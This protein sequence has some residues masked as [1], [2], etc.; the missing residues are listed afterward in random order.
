MEY[1]GEKIHPASPGGWLR[2][3]I[4]RGDV[5]TK[6][7]AVGW[8]ESRLANF[9]Q[10]RP[11]QVVATCTG[12]AALRLG[13][14][15]AGVRPGDEVIIPALTF[16]ATASAVLQ[17]FAKPVC[18]DVDPDTW[19]MDPKLIE[20]AITSQTRAIVPVHLYG[21]P[22]DMEPICATA[23]LH[24]IPVVSDACEALGATYD[25]KHVGSMSEELFAALSFNGNK[26][27]T[28]GGGGALICANADDAKRAREMLTPSGPGD[29]GGLRFNERMTGLS[30]AL[31]MH[32][33]YGVEQ[34]I[35]ARCTL[36]EGAAYTLSSFV[37]FQ[38][39][40]HSGRPSWWKTAFLLPRG[41]NR[42]SF[43]SEMAALGV[44]M[45]PVFP[46]LSK[47][48]Q[49]PVADDISAG[50]MCFPDC[51][52]NDARLVQELLRDVL[53]RQ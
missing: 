24:N 38:Q 34:R 4:E 35:Q 52:P 43:V 17:L 8:F 15:L 25:G 20:G 22:A 40:Q 14:Y 30:A 31:G 45:R 12:T 19:C 53:N 51:A 9:L 23:K 21:V 44:T 11:E 13:L 49:C 48:G 41:V 42:D 3:V 26:V 7:V 27:V 39:K 2:A 6:S 29:P 1:W 33:L 37:E 47:P 10:V 28:T 50:G 18:V 16:R 5:S 36:R 46:V 32:G